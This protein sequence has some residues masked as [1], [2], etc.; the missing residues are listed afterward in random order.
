MAAGFAFDA[1][2]AGA[3]AGAATTFNAVRWSR[4]ALIS[5]PSLSLRSVSFAMLAL[6][7]AMDLAVLDTGAFLAATFATGFA[8]FAAVFALGF[9]AALVATFFAVAIFKFLSIFNL[10]KSLCKCSIVARFCARFAKASQY[11]PTA[12]NARPVLALNTC[13][14]SHSSYEKNHQIFGRCTACL[15][16]G[17]QC[18]CRRPARV[19]P[20]WPTTWLPGSAK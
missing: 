6:I 18:L 3:A 9:T 15:R 8:T 12:V 11:A 19:L 16:R 17:M 1:T 13:D 7:L 20:A 5:A 4:K 2:G 14:P 10:H